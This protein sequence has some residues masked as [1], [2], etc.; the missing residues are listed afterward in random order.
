MYA[1]VHDRYKPFKSLAFQGE[2]KDD[3]AIDQAHQKAQEISVSWRGED[4]REKSLGRGGRR[5][6]QSSATTIPPILS[7]VVI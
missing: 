3:E 7:A 2:R 1:Y 4:T 6:H 5:K